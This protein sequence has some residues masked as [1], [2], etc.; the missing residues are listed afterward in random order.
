MKRRGVPTRRLALAAAVVAVAVA[1][2]LPVAAAARVQAQGGGADALRI[3]AAA[4][5]TEVFPKIDKR[6]TY[7]FASSNSLLQQIRQGAPADVFAAASPRE[8]AAAYREGLCELPVTFAYNKLVIIVPDENRAHIDSVFDLKR[9]GVKVVIAQQG[10]PIGDYTRQLLRNLGISKAVLANVVSQEPDVKAVV[11]KIVLGEGDAGFVYRTDVRP[12][13]NDVNFYRLPTWAQP[14]VR[15]QI[16]VVKDSNHKAA[17]RAFVKRVLGPIGRGNLS[18]A[19]FT[20]PP[21]R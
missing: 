13:A 6:P 1:A 5:L 8:P 14:P 4:S 7:N 18:G 2:A 11:S 15:Y 20:L 16:C 21:K 3:F 12:V 9:P 19:L 10:V 17:A